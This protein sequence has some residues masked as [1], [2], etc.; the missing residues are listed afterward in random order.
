MG[1]GCLAPELKQLITNQIY[2]LGI[3]KTVLAKTIQ[4][5]EMCARC[6]TI[7]FILFFFFEKN[8]FE[9]VSRPESFLQA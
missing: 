6:T 8:L 1:K 4:F 3:G 9:S 2:V 5:P 7:M